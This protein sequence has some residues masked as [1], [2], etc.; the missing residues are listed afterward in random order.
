MLSFLL[1]MLFGIYHVYVTSPQTFDTIKMMGIFG[2]IQTQ[3]FV[4]HA[5]N[6]GKKIFR[7]CESYVNKN[8]IPREKL[9]SNEHIL[10]CNVISYCLED[11]PSKNKYKFSKNRLDE[12]TTIKKDTIFV[13]EI[14][15][16][17][18]VRVGLVNP[19]NEPVYSMQTEYK[20]I[21]EEYSSG[22]PNRIKC[23]FMCVEVIYDENNID[24]TETLKEYLYPGNIILNK[25]FIR[26]VMF[27]HFGIYIKPNTPFSLHTVDHEV[28]INDVH[29]NTDE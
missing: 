19:S 20:R 29:F 8:F 5:V 1:L 4:E 12:Q 26:M 6:E 21:E 25:H 3:M 2:L 16:D 24:I 27:E 13:T 10:E 18:F 28:N 14:K 15:F 22:Y 7:L 11:N 23:P 17:N 9:F